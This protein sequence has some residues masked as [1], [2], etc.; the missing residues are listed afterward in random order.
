MNKRLIWA[1]AAAI[2]VCTLALIYVQLSWIFS[3]SQAAQNTFTHNIQLILE[4]VVSDI[5]EKDTYVTPT[6]NQTSVYDRPNPRQNNS[7]AFK[8]EI[9]IR[10]RISLDQTAAFFEKEFSKRNITVAYEFGITNEL[11]EIIFCTSGFDAASH[12]NTYAIN[13]FPKD[14]DYFQL[15]TLSLSIPQKNSVI[16]EKTGVMIL[17]SLLLILIIT[18]TFTANLLIIFRQKRLSEMKNDFVNNITHE[19]KTPIATISLAAQMLNDPNIQ[20]KAQRTP[21]LSETILSES[22]RLQFLVEKVLQIAIFERG[23]LKLKYKELDITNLLFNTLAHFSLSLEK[24]HVHLKTVIDTQGTIV[25]ADETHLTNVFTNLIDNAIKY[26][27]EENPEL[28]ITA[29]HVEDGISITI[30]D[31]GIGIHQDDLKKI[32]DKF[33]RVSTGNIHTVKGFGLGLSYVKKIVEM[34]RGT[35]KPESEP[36][37]GTSF[38]VVLPVIK[39]M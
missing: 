1:L 4:N 38:T 25:W 12:E 8:T 3:I 31:N 21:Y 36:G 39:K 30:A 13:L 37:K 9:P 11:G 24:N 33:Y 2:A 16:R 28:M 34:H 20:N 15:Y 26:R 32:F 35:I 6:R 19:L 27:T 14:P 7:A 18:G 23:N 22:K 5:A 29:Q 10:Q 17:A